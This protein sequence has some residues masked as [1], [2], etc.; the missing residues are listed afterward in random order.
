MKPTAQAIIQIGVVFSVLVSIVASVLLPGTLPAADFVIQALLLASA[1]IVPVFGGTHRSTLVVPVMAG[2]IWGLWR[3]AYF[4]PTTN[5]DV[6]GFGY[7]ITAFQF[8][9]IGLIVYG[10][11][12]F[13]VD[14]RRK[15]A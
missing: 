4:D 1:I 10:A 2:M 14:C 9:L 7:M 15:R 3:M 11:R 8:G 12:K 13:V 5:N 6:L